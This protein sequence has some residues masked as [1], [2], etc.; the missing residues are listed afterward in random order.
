MDRRKFVKDL[1]IYSAGTAA[2]AQVVDAGRE[3]MAATAQPVVTIARGKDWSKLVEQALA[4]LGGMGAFVKKGQSVCVKPNIS[5]DTGPDYATNTHPEIV[6]AI[7]QQSLDA[8]ASKDV[9]F[10]YTLRSKRRC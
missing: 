1:S 9:V 10:D 5:F 8:G 6:K 4:P 3:A 2:A 7:V